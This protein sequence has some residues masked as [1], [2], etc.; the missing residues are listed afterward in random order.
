MV[1]KESKPRYKKGWFYAIVIIVGLILIS[2]YFS[3]QAYY[4]T[5]STEYNQIYSQIEKTSNQINNIETKYSQDG[6]VYYYEFSDSDL[7]KYLT[8][9]NGQ[10]EN[11][12]EL[13]T[14]VILNEKYLKSQGKSDLMISEMIK[15]LRSTKEKLEE[16]RLQVASIKNMKNI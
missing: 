9:I 16:A 15:E 4:E 13:T 14:W 10:I 6:L 1:K 2:I 8:L 5:A 12:D 11:Y 3:N 7:S